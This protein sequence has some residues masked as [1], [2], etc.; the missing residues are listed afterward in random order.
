[1]TS[2][3]LSITPVTAGSPGFS[4]G[5]VVPETSVR[6]GIEII[7]LAHA[8]MIPSSITI[9]PISSSTSSKS[10]EE[11]SKDKKSSKSK[12]DDKNRLEKKKKKKVCYNFKIYNNLLNKYCYS[13]M[14]VL[15][16]H[17]IKFL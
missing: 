17:R 7:P 16:D 1:M 12:S 13:G 11:R 8:S 10:S 6:P 15:W 5:G 14:E 3:T 9:T 2:A 4:P